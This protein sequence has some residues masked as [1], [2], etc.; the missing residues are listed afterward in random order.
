MT[1]LALRTSGVRER[2]RRA[3]RRHV[4]AH[5]A[6]AVAVAAAR[7]GA[8]HRRSPTASTPRAGSAA[9]C[10]S[11]WSAT[12]VPACTSSPEDPTRVGPRR[13]ASPPASC[14]ASTSC[15]GSAWCCSPASACAPSCCAR[16]PAGSRAAPPATRCAPMPSPSAS[17]AASPPTSGRRCCSATPTGSPACS[18]TSAARCRSS[19]PARRTRWTCP[20]R[21]CCATVVQESQRPRLRERIVFLEDYDMHVA[22]YLVQGADV[23]LNMPRRPLEASGTSGMKAAVNGGLNLSVLDGWW[24]EGYTPETGWADR[25]RRA[26]R[27]PGGERR[28]RG[29][30]PLHAAGARGDPG[31]L[32]ARQLRP[33]RASGPR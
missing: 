16:G 11:C 19:S 12:S 2:R 26:V 5:V 32:L 4:A 20:A 3:A 9:R 14:G 6:G 30:G 18:T 28:R 29:R 21:S 13:R 1:P 10:T 31:V 7:R 27:G 8:D 23:W 25:Q 33:S 22:R 24:A 15:A 17:P